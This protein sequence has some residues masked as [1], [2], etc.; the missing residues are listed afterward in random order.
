MDLK[1]IYLC[2]LVPEFGLKGGVITKVP[3]RIPPFSQEIK[4]YLKVFP[5]RGCCCKL[6]LRDFDTC[7]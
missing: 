3:T 6:V 4:V 5:G 7:S 1:V 2:K